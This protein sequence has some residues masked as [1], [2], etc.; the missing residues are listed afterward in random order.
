MT[1]ARGRRAAVPS[2]QTVTSWPSRGNSIC[3]RSRR[4]A[5]SSANKTRNP[6]WRIFSIISSSLNSLHRT[7]SGSSGYRV[8]PAGGGRLCRLRRAV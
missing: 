7:L 5:S 2:A 6:P 4:C 3:I 1:R 8:H